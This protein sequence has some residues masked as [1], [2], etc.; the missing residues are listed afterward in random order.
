MDSPYIDINHDH[1]FGL[2]HLPYGVFSYPGQSKRI[3]VRV[4]GHILDLAYLEQQGLSK[5]ITPFSVFRQATLNPLAELGRLSWHN[6]R[7]WIQEIL[8]SRHSPLKDKNFH[9]MA[10]LPVDQALLHLPFYSRGYTDFYSSEQH[11]RNVGALYRDP[12][13]ALPK[14]WKHLPI[15]YHGRSS[16]LMVSGTPIVRPWGQILPPDLSQPLFRPT[17]K[18]DFEIEVGLFIGQPSQAFQP[19]PIG[20]AEDY[21]FGLVLVNDWSARDIQ[22]FEYQPL[23]PFLG[24]NFATSLSPWVVPLA[25]LQPFR[26]PMPALDVQVVSYLEQSP[27]YSYDIPL[28]LTLE[29]ATGH[30]QS[31]IHTNFCHQYWSMAQQIAHHTVN[32][33]NLEVGDLL[34]SGTISGP[35]PSSWGSLLEISQNGQ[36]PLTLGNGKA[37]TFLEDGDDITITAQC[38]N[39][40]H[41]VSFGEVRGKI[42]PALPNFS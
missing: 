6:I 20:Q 10:F 25:A 28:R 2:D 30:Q 34:A 12:A 31:L 33:C 14:N 36:Q 32:G 26:Q 9:R 3:G 8:T 38:Q 35:E 5:S 42:L 17:R 15:A 11:A 19:I 24:K 39:G 16:S 21:I 27:R 40:K 13:H 41:H 23:G 29:T 1:G 18:L 37:R 7:E 4:G 22:A